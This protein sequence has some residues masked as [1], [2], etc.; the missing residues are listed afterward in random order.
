MK[1]SI[2]STDRL[3]STLSNLILNI[4]GINDL[5]DLKLH[6]CLDILKH[7]ILV[8][9]ASKE[10]YRQY[11]MSSWDKCC[12]MEDKVGTVFHFDSKFDQLDEFPRNNS[13]G[14][15][16]HKLYY[17]VCNHSLNTCNTMSENILNRVGCSL[18]MFEKSNQ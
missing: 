4:F 14:I 11:N 6:D 3:H 7:T 5:Y 1:L 13:K 9:A 2:C 16:Q 15:M 17:R 8:I 12:I 18:C 10:H